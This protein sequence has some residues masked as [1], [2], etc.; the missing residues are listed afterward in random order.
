MAN[1][2]GITGNT[3]NANTRA[4]WVV[5][6]SPLINTLYRSSFNLSMMLFMINS[7]NMLAV[8]VTPRK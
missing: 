1:T 6:E 4:C 3:R 8:I 2:A 5:S 7:F